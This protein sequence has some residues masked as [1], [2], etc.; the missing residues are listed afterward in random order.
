MNVGLILT[1]VSIYQ[2][3][4]GALVLWVGVLS[5]V[6]LRRHLWLYQ[7][8]SL[9]IVT[10]GVSLVGLAGSLVKKAVLDED[11]LD[12]SLRA[13]VAIAKREDNDP[14]KVVLGVGLILFAQIFTATQYVVEE[15]IM[16]RYKVEPLAAVTLEGF[17]GLTTTLIGMPILHVLFHNRSAYFDVPRG[18]AQIISSPG[19]IWTSVAIAFSIGAFNYFGL[20]VTNRVSATT[21]STVDT[22]RTLGIWIVSLGLG[23]E[24]LVWPV[25]LLQV[26]G[27][28]ML[29]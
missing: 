4:R 1:P 6:F 13:L 12:L 24:V 11:P 15:K 18:W 3:S 25:S 16:S 22:C 19:V 17:F 7:W 23:W 14:A 29:V 20:S 28:G 2:M 9:L 5:V 21:R 8:V 10:F 27:F 26:T